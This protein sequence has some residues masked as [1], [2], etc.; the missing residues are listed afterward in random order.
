MIGDVEDNQQG[1]RS[2][3]V[4]TS[5]STKPFVTSSVPDLQLH[6]VALERK[7]FES[8]VHANSGKEDLAEL[9]VSVSDHD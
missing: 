2:P 5:D 1:M 9:I 4:R 3:V 7:G 6:F 8:E